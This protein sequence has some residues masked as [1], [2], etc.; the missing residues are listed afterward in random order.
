MYFCDNEEME[1]I[2][3]NPEGTQPPRPDVTDASQF[4]Q[5]QA[6]SIP[7]QISTAP[8]IEEEKIALKKSDPLKYVKLMMA[9]RES[10]SDISVFGASTQ[11]SVSA[12]EASY[13]EL[14]QQVKKAVFE[15]DLF[16][17][18]KGDVTAC[19][20]M[21]KLISQINIIA[22]PTNISEALID[23]QNLIDQI[24]AENNRE[25][26]AT[27][28][29]QEKEQ[30]QATEFDKAISTSKASKDLMASRITTQ[31]KFDTYTAS[32]TL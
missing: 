26:D 3:Q 19:F 17:F 11:S 21:K 8:L 25:V 14:F 5:T 15:T 32:I 30:A 9:I 1:E 31:T 13:D 20:W 12:N 24:C 18:L 22:F 23:I 6:R 28:K 7:T 16:E 4:I 2:G 27:S 10:S 29:L